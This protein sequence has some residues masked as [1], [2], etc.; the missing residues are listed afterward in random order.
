MTISG[1]QLAMSLT[2]AAA[3]RVFNRLAA[4]MVLR[5]RSLRAHEPPATPDRDQAEV[6]LRL[7]K[8]S[9]AP[10]WPLSLNWQLRRSGDRDDASSV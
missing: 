1:Q 6:P 3:E 2:R 4:M 9:S 8:L 10:L 7:N 5:G